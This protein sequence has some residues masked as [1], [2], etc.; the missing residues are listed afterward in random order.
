MIAEGP[1]YPDLVAY[2]WENVASKGLALLQQII[3]KGVRDGEF[4]KTCLEK[5]PQLLFS[6]VVL[7]VIWTIIFKNQQDLDTD[8][9][10]EAHVNFLI[11]AIT[12]NK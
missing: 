11:D 12:V 5:F 6:P 7:S 4:K 8:A 2:Y 10:L 3:Y 9:M 1:K